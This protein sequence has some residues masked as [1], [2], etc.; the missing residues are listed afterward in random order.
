MLS[1]EVKT[2]LAQRTQMTKYPKYVGTDDEIIIL[3]SE[4]NS[5][6][7]YVVTNDPWSSFIVIG[8]HNFI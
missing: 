5:M 6:I 7:T 4:V 8:N 3:N 2:H 1:D